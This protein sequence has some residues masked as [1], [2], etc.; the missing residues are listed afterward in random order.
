[1]P[2]SRRSPLAPAMGP[3]SRSARH[4]NARSAS[5]PVPTADSPAHHGSSSSPFV[6]GLPSAGHSKNDDPTA[7]PA[8]TLKIRRGADP[9]P[10]RPSVHLRRM[11]NLDAAN[12]AATLV[13][14]KRV[15]LSLRAVDLAEDLVG[16]FGPGQGPGVVV[17][18]TGER[19]D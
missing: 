10:C 8:L 4:L 19:A 18:V 7:A 1:M 11:V 15:G 2:R 14:C 17:P 16:V 3:S 13:V 12:V 6:T 5:R 9:Q